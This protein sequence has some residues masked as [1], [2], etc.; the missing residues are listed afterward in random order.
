[1]TTAWDDPHRDVLAD[2]RQAWDNATAAP[3]RF[4]PPIISP[5]LRQ[6]LVAEYG[7]EA[8]RTMPLSVFAADLAGRAYRG[9]IDRPETDQR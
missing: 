4:E 3:Y 5:W 2:M 7:E 9:E 6:R 1:M 8:V